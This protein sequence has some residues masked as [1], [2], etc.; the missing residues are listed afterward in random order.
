MHVK[1]S[2]TSVYALIA[3]LGYAKADATGPTFNTGHV[4]SGI[5]IL[6]AISTLILPDSPRGSTGTLLLSAGMDTAAGEDIIRFE[7]TNSDSTWDVLAYT[8]IQTPAN[9][10]APIP[11]PNTAASPGDHVTMH[12]VY[13]ESSQKY[14]Q[15]IILN[16]NDVSNRTA[17]EAEAKSWGSF[18]TCQDQGTCGT[19]PSHQWIDTK[20]TLSDADPAYGSTLVKSQGVTGD[21]KSKDGGVTWSS[22]QFKIPE[23]TFK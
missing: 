6:E 8:L 1:I 10:R 16:G 17:G 18:V 4:S 14:T 3:V 9:T 22:S 19:V 5:Y 23:Y 13:D 20:I 2:A 12:Y 7:A 21:L 11:V 15:Y